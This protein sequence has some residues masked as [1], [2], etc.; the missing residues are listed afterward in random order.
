MWS[1]NWREVCINTSEAST[2]RKS[3]Y[4]DRISWRGVYTTVGGETSMLW[5]GF[6][7]GLFTIPGHLNTRNSKIDVTEAY[8]TR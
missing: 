7:L 2:E 8:K 4:I 3:Q 5:A 1:Q 6:A